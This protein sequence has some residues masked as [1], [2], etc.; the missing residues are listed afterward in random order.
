MRAHSVN[1]S[2]PSRWLLALVGL[3][4]L[5]AAPA[6]AKVPTTLLFEG[7]LKNKA[8]GPAA[9]GKYSL[10]FSMYGSQTAQSAF[11]TEK[12]VSVTVS[13]GHF[14]WTLG[15]KAA[16]STVALGSA[17]EVWLG[18]A[19]G[20][21]PELS[22]QQ[23]H[24]HAFALRAQVATV[25]EGLSC[26]GCVNSTAIKWIGNLD[27]SGHGLQV[28]A[29]SAK[30]VSA[31]SIAAGV[32][33]GDGSKLSGIKQPSGACPAGQVMIGINV[34]ATLKCEA[35]QAGVEG[36]A[37]AKVSNGAISNQF[38]NS[39]SGKKEIGIPDNNPI[40]ISDEINV[41]DLGNAE[42]LTVDIDI[43]NSALEGL[44]V[45]LFG[46]DNSKYT[47]YNKNGSGNALK[48]TYPF[49][50]KTIDGDLT[51]WVGKN[52]KGKW[53]IHVIDHVK[54][55][56]AVDDGAIHSWTV[57]LHTVSNSKIQITGKL[58]ANGG[59]TIGGSSEACNA[60][61]EGLL[62]KNKDAN[63]ELCEG[64][65]WVAMRRDHC[66]PPGVIID[67]ICMADVFAGNADFVNGA[68][69]CAS[70]HADIC[71]DSQAWTLRRSNMLDSTANWTSS[72]ADNDGNGWS[73]VTGTSTDS[74]GYTSK[75]QVPCCYNITPPRAAD[76]VIAGVRT[77]YVH[78]T[79]N[80]YWRQA[81]R[82]CSAMN[83]DLCSKAEYWV[84]RKEKVISVNV[85]SSDHS[86]ND[87]PSYEKGIG[88]GADNPSINSHYGFACCATQRA[89]KDSCPVAR[90]AGV[91]AVHIA[92]EMQYT[93]DQVATD[94][95]K[96]GA[97]VCSMSQTAVLRN[98][99]SLTAAA[100]WSA[101]Y[102][103][104]DSNVTTIAVGSAGDNHANTS[105]YGYACC[106]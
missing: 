52:P 50:S 19:V 34:D 21:D 104:N 59:V 36:G 45:I 53:R 38:T 94:C 84:L 97:Q 86:D 62:R 39:F 43:S 70:L 51:V 23:I 44:E 67:G 15:A 4:L 41:P 33:L 30:S 9:D 85:W 87:S 103:D 11:W 64:G 56:G 13:G 101:S 74:P 78:N 12:D 77:V 55:D 22:R 63:L 14:V 54:K 57:N 58:I 100:N 91:C 6:F 31:A 93:W 37:L 16:I 82:F 65:K 60:E 96:R 7:A 8:G 10:T 95:A 26:T 48:A 75:W 83:A 102:S 79:Q 27:L 5:F 98:K 68:L 24:S 1:H 28:D 40:G 89:D 18:V 69:R 66:P 73:E 35:L 92:N 20:A 32:Y 80:V 29:I 61:N 88:N 106:M 76:K 42:K 2:A 99:K 46:P 17:P 25:A 47:L 90:V 71:T 81:A 72:M 3:A 49:P 105:K